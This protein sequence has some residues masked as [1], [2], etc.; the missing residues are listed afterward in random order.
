MGDNDKQRLWRKRVEVFLAS[1]QNQGAGCQEHGLPAHQ[2]GYWLRKFK[3]ESQEL[4]DE[5]NRWVNLQ[6]TVPF[7]SGVSLRIGD[8]IVDIESGFDK[9]LLIDVVRALVAVC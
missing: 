8:L 4:P 9:Q 1:G 7:S 5:D 2:L 6:G 3:N